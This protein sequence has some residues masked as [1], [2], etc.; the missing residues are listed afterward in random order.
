[1]SEPPPPTRPERPGRRWGEDPLSTFLQAAHTNAQAAFHLSPGAYDRL[2]ELHTIFE[3]LGSNLDNPPDQVVPFFLYQSH[4]AFL[5]AVRLALSGE[6]APAYM[7]LRGCIEQ[8]L[9]GQYINRNPSTFEIWRNRTESAES[10]RVVRTTFT[11][12]NVIE[13]LRGRDQRLGEIAEALYDRTID[14][15]AHPNES[16]LFSALTITEDE[17]EETVSFSVAYFQGPGVP[18]DLALK[19]AA[20]AGVT[21]LRIFELVFGER[22]RILGLSDRLRAVSN[23]L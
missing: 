1:M 20:Q 15:G 5:G 18:L 4:R 16:A 11:F 19:T 17:R 8:A 12:R 2:R 23:G 21:A 22:M 9:Y 13:S 14:H 10:R 6:L 7:V 3:E